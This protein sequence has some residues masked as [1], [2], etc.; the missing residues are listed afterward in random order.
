M[1][2]IQRS[3]LRG[4]G[5]PIMKNAVE[6][7]AIAK[8]VADYVIYHLLIEEPMSAKELESLVSDITEDRGVTAEDV[9]EIARIAIDYITKDPKVEVKSKGKEGLWLYHK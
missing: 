2:Y 5:H 8:S 4:G 1:P 9:D 6:R 3:T 7:A